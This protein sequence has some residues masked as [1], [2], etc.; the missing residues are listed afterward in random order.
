[1]EPSAG[2][3]RTPTWTPISTWTSIWTWTR[4]WADPKI[5]MDTNLNTDTN[6]E[7]EPWRP[8]RKW[9]TLD[10]RRLDV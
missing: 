9:T 7:H 2:A 1:M 8:A 5:D 4:I 6:L 10:T 3:A